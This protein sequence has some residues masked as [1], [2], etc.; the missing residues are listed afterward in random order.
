MFI[1]LLAKE[2]KQTPIKVNSADPGRRLFYP[3]EGESL[4]R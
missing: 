4:V 2:L 3:S 1:V